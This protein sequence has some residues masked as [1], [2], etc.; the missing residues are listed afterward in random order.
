MG[1]GLSTMS[2]CTL[3]RISL[4]ALKTKTSKTACVNEYTFEY[5]IVLSQVKP[6]K[7]HGQAKSSHRHF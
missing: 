5:N 3:E 4:S 7:L 1:R 6:L 2:T